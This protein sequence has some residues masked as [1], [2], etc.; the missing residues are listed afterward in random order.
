MALAHK[1][2]TVET[3]PWRFTEKNK[4]PHRMPER[5]RLRARAFFRNRDIADRNL[6]LL[7]GFLTRYDDLFDWHLPDGG[8]V[9]YPRYRGTEGVEC[10]CNRL[11]EEHGVMLLPASVYRSELL[12]TPSDR[13]R[14]GFGRRDFAAEAALHQPQPAMRRAG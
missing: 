13:F 8:V 6:A 7:T 11:I 4:L 12:P 9:S 2:L 14:I 10:F 3:A 1:G 5:C